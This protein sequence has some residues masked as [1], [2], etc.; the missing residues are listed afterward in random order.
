[1]T[2][3]AKSFKFRQ[4][5]LLRHLLLFGIPT[6][7]L[8]LGADCS[9]ELIAQL[10]SDRL[11]PSDCGRGDVRILMCVQGSD[12]LNRKLGV[13]VREPLATKFEIAGK[14]MALH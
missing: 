8:P 11:R 1:M 2:A 14:Y 9:R 5:R 13:R 3:L 12:V 6:H 4:D 7:E 10:V